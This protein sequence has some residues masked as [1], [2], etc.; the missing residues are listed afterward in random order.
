MQWK[1]LGLVW[2]P[3]GTLAWARSHA[4]VPTPFRWNEDVV[5]VFVSCLDEKGRCR[6]SYVDVAANDPTRVLGTGESP[7]LDLGEPGTFDDNG[8]MMSSVVEPTPGTL[9]MYYAGFE[10]CTQVRYRIFTGLAISRD[11]GT[12][13]QRVSRSAILDR[14]DDELYF[15]GG[16][17]ALYDEGKFKL[18]YVAGSEWTD[19][20][21]K[22][23]PQ[24]ELR[25]L[26]ST[27]GIRWA[28][29][30]TTCLKISESDEHGFGRPWVVKRGPNDYQL[31][32]SVRRRS[33]GAYRLGY[34][35]SSDGLHWDRKDAE[36]GL[37]VSPGEFD[38]KAIMYSA[39]MHV[40]SRT[41][42]FYNGENF[43]EQGFAVAELQR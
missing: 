1:K 30:G 17:C 40:G 34:A 36:F 29:Q 28:P 5:R 24:Y 16:P 42:C 14:A 12:T 22:P 32:Y 11:R 15:R 31:C 27:D 7:L 3:E 25:Y 9:Y 33:F 43:G 8:V 6:P 39:L 38:G 21:G 41:Y 10:I 23:M 13:F 37:D 19:I 35:E 4:T 20:A 2:K 26:E 18:W